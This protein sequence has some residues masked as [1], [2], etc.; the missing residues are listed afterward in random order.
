MSNVPI[1]DDWNGDYCCY[2]VMWPDSRGYLAILRG[3]IT[4]AADGRY[5]L[6]SS[7]SITETQAIIRETFDHNFKNE[8]VILSCNDGTNQALLAIAAA[9]SGTA[10]GQ[11]GGSNCCGGGTAG[12]GQ[13]PANPG[14]VD[15]GTIDPESPGEEPPPEGFPSWE[16]YNLQRCGVAKQIIEDLEQSLGNLTL[17]IVGSLT[18]EALIELLLVAL[19]LTISTAGLAAIAGLLI[20]IGSTIVVASALGYVNDNEDKLICALLSGNSAYT[21][22]NNFLNKY[23]QIVDEGSVDVLEAF[24]M[25]QLIAYLVEQTVI[26]RMY[27]YEPGIQYEGVECAP[28][29]DDC[30]IGNAIVA[31]YTIEN[32]GGG[33]LL[34]ESSES[35]ATYS[36]SDSAFPMPVVVKDGMSILVEEGDV[37]SFCFLD[38]P[39]PWGAC[40][41]LTFSDETTVELENSGTI[42]DHVAA[43]CYDLTEYV[44]KTIVKFEFGINRSGGGV[45]QL[46]GIGLN[47]PCTES[48]SC[49][50]P[51]SP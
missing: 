43:R 2:S 1:P 51:P 41:M 35:S 31:A 4:L 23:N 12:G 25:K 37:W 5:W 17:V 32:D 18:I 24:L 19:T 38:D 3:L 29:M 21:S 11:S 28:C 42:V 6:A 50:T 16:A 27:I 8:E 40:F 47:C 33:T 45:W 26:N 13:Y 15:T 39:T 36:L 34:L 14:G 46:T 20:T 30:D 9:L 49:F 10:P 22:R 7:G 44:G 48:E